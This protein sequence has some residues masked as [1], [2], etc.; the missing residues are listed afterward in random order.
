[1]YSARNVSISA[2]YDRSGGTLDLLLSADL[3]TD[4]PPGNFPMTVGVIFPSGNGRRFEGFEAPFALNATT[5]F[6]ATCTLAEYPPGQYVMSLW[7]EGQHLGD[8]P[9]RVGDDEV[10]LV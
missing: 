10:A 9:F 2:A 1:M 3:I 8:F 4:G 6:A 7:I 5:D